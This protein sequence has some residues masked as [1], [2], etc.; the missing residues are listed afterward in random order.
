M[1][2]D[3]SLILEWSNKRKENV[4]R[5]GVLP[6]TLCFWIDPYWE[7][8][9]VKG[10]EMEDGMHFHIKYVMRPIPQASLL[11]KELWKKSLNPTV[12]LQF[13]M[14]LE[15]NKGIPDFRYSA[16]FP[17]DLLCMPIDDLDSFYCGLWNE[18]EDVC[19]CM[20]AKFLPYVKLSVTILTQSK[21]PSNIPMLRN[22]LPGPNLESH[23][24]VFT[25]GNWIANA[26]AKAYPKVN[27]IYYLPRTIGRNPFQDFFFTQE[28]TMY[29]TEGTNLPPI[30][31][32]YILCNGLIVRG[33][34]LDTAEKIILNGG[35]K[36]KAQVIQL[37]ALMRD[38]LMC[39]TLCR[40]EGKYR[41]DMCNGKP[42]ED[43]PQCLQFTPPG[44]LETIF[45]LDD[46]EGLGQQGCVHIVELFQAIA[47]R[48]NKEEKEAGGGYGIE[49]SLYECIEKQALTSPL[50]VEKETL[51]RLMFLAI[52]IGEMF[53]NGEL[54]PHMC[55]AESLISCFTTDANHVM[56]VDKPIQN[57]DYPEGHSFGMLLYEKGFIQGAI[58]LEN[59]GIE[60]VETSLRKTPFEIN[61][62][63]QL[64]AIAHIHKENFG[65]RISLTHSEEDTLYQKVCLGK[66]V[67]FFTQQTNGTL[68]YG[69]TPSLLNERFI[70]F[71]GM[72]LPSMDSNYAVLVPVE[73]MIEAMHYGTGPWPRMKDAKAML[74]MYKQVI[75]DVNK[76]ARL[77]MPPQDTEREYLSRM[78]NWGLIEEMNLISKTDLPRPGVLATVVR[79]IGRKSAPILPPD[80]FVNWLAQH[81]NQIR[82]TIHAFMHS[83]IYLIFEK[84]KP[85]GYSSISPSSSKISFGRMI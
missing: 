24:R 3:C 51:Q 65:T 42:T 79:S 56:K 28:Q 80:E 69:T 85:L 46:C 73:K 72:Q 48:Y 7:G 71:N 49:E 50:R 31:A 18:N 62:M 8:K 64:G 32:V 76:F 20:E 14:P 41:D 23:Q 57:P 11:D 21:L 12:K 61:A 29:Q 1:E 19:D 17:V 66:G 37:L 55:Q 6:P 74:L 39:F 38:V 68:E 35:P 67:I 45:G 53:L 22:L 25:L 4:K 60:C 58:L 27:S 47:R 52:G 82:F 44:L 54:D 83:I 15:P 2:I 26:L 36:S 40:C 75:E 16:T 13:F 10:V 59:T 77:W 33:L 63:A 84:E 81:G 43:Q 30:L 70:R 5:F 34:T 78:N 9:W